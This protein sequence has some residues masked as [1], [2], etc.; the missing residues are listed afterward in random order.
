MMLITMQVWNFWKNNISIVTNNGEHYSEHFNKYN[1]LTEMHLSLLV[2]VEIFF[3]SFS[4]ILQ[5]YR[6]FIN[7]ICV[8]YTHHLSCIFS[9]FCET[10]ILFNLIIFV[11]TLSGRYCYELSQNI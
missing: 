6:N 2:N 7:R 1:F 11:G 8:L 4:I 9:F 3:F 5:F 10:N